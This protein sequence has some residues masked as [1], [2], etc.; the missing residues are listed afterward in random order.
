MERSQSPALPLPAN[1]SFAD[2]V[3]REFDAF[4]NE[5]DTHKEGTHAFFI[6]LGDKT[7]VVMG[8][9]EHFGSGTPAEIRYKGQMIKPGTLLR[10]PPNAAHSL[11]W[12]W[13]V[14][15]PPG[16]VPL[17][18][19]QEALPLI[20]YKDEMT[21]LTAEG[22]KQAVLADRYFSGPYL[23]GH[24]VHDSS[25][26]Q[27][28]DGEAYQAVRIGDPVIQTSTGIV[29]AAVKDKV[30]EIKS[31]N[32]PADC[33]IA[34]LSFPQPVEKRNAPLTEV[35]GASVPAD[36][37]VDEPF[38]QRLMP[39]R[40]LATRIGEKIEDAWARNPF[41]H[42]MPPEAVNRWG[43][44]DHFGKDWVFDRQVIYADDGR[45]VRIDSSCDSKGSK[46]AMMCVNWL[47]EKFQQP[48]EIRKTAKGGALVAIWHQ[49]PTWVAALISLDSGNTPK[50]MSVSL[51]VA[52]AEKE[53]R[54]QYREE[55]F[56]VSAAADKGTFVGLA[57]ALAAQAAEEDFGVIEKNPFSNPAMAAKPT[58][59]GN[60][61]MK[62]NGVDIQ[63]NSSARP[64]TAPLT[65]GTSADEPAR[66]TVSGTRMEIRTRALQK[67]EL[68][69]QVA[70]AY[71]DL[72]EDSRRAAKVR[73]VSGAFEL[74]RTHA[75]RHPHLVLN[76]DL[77]L[78]M[79]WALVLSE[80]GELQGSPALQTFVQVIQTE[81]AVEKAR[82]CAQ[83]MA[84]IYAAAK[85]AGSQDFN[86]VKTAEEA[87]QRLLKGV[88]GSGAFKDKVFACLPV[89]ELPAAD[90]ALH[91][92]FDV[93]Q[94]SLRYIPKSLSLKGYDFSMESFK[95]LALLVTPQ[96]PAPSSSP[97]RG[98]IA[99]QHRNPTVNDLHEANSA[100]HAALAMRTAQ[101]LAS[102]YNAAMSTGAKE[103]DDVK[104]L[105]Q[106]IQ[107]IT[108]GV[109]GGGVFA[110]NRFQSKAT[111]EEVAAARVYLSYDANEKMMRYSSKT[112]PA[113]GNVTRPQMLEVGRDVPI[114][115][116]RRQESPKELANTFASVFN[117]ASAT[118]AEE[119][120]E[121]Q[122]VEEAIDLMLSG[123]K[124][125]GAFEKHNFI[126][127]TTHEW[128][129]A[130]LPFLEFDPEQQI[131][132]VK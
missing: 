89:A 110:K 118:G 96:Q 85:A 60:A 78:I 25:S 116:K 129:K 55:A 8:Y 97:S 67:L 39:A 56:T 70:E 57:R 40:A 20:L 94:R 4:H 109:Y 100:A 127:K 62:R 79:E 5:N 34:W 59:S 74:L 46:S 26:V 95:H 18:R 27:L 14:D 107:R 77:R 124:G 50:L 117:A 1:V 24:V 16:A 6:Q 11:M 99:T 88:K 84:S 49:E 130:A 106:A 112:G 22:P 10:S 123:V 131:L 132:R 121:V 102:I 33:G 108:T 36:P 23:P 83:Q 93:D 71:N 32:K 12:V 44:Q 69:G 54:E 115:L 103:L 98:D 125:G 2:V 63:M 53:L 76:E 7:A 126:V 42:R 65:K 51:H 37:S 87:V 30:P 75:E 58:S 43:M 68:L 80:T 19:E 105:E 73:G 31:V 9:D 81:V 21:I 29:V 101:T 28:L 61:V 122:T 114:I 47:A 82:V 91:L 15:L 66:P 128:A 111:S 3:G 41:I 92:R 119:I 120:E 13:E 90:V 35:W 45:V 64:V 104:T 52:A 72:P 38:V 48:K 113:V 17:V 86:D